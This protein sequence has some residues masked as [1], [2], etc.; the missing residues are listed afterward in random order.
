MKKG[1]KSR[2]AGISTVINIII[3]CNMW[4]HLFIVSSLKQSNT[5][6][7]YRIL[8]TTFDMY[9]LCMKVYKSYHKPD[10]KLSGAINRH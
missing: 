1:T 2:P 6:E 9:S 7:S 10:N 5:S 4:G 3:T 8:S